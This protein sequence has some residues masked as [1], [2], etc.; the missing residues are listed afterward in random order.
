M[1]DD[2]T[3]VTSLKFFPFA[4]VSSRLNLSW[5]LLFLLQFLLGIGSAGKKILFIWERNKTNGCFQHHIIRVQSM[6][7]DKIQ[8]HV[9]YGNHTFCLTKAIIHTHGNTNMLRKGICVSDNVCSDIHLHILGLRWR[10]CSGEWL[11]HLLPFL[12]PQNFPP[13]FSFLLFSLFILHFLFPFPPHFRSTWNNISEKFYNTMFPLNDVDCTSQY[14]THS[15]SPRRT[16]VVPNQSY[17]PCPLPSFLAPSPP[18]PPFSL[19]PH[20]P[21]S[22]IAHGG[23]W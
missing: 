3:S 2:L 9:K 13:L 5:H 23:L 20:L 1:A 8:I 17:C 6:A 21:T 16:F 22:F 12:C 19:S 7:A 14:H 4:S 10:I 18:P 15:L 11:V